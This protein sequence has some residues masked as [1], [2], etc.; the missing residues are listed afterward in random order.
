MQF[1]R[2]KKV[3]HTSHFKLKLFLCLLTKTIRCTFPKNP[4]FASAM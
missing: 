2:L 1:E 4:N 3:A